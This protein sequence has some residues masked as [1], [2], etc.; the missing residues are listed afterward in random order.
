MGDFTFDLGWFGLAD[1]WQNRL[2]D[3]LPRQFRH[4]GPPA[5]GGLDQHPAQPGGPPLVPRACS[6]SL[7]LLTQHRR[8]PIFVAF[9]VPVA[10]GEDVR[11]LPLALRKAVL[12]RLAKGA[13]CWIAITD[14]VP[15][16]RAAGCSNSSPR[17]TSRDRGEAPLRSAERSGGRS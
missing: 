4:T 2:P 1:W 6:T 9:D 8:S 12:K 5:P 3:V 16:A 11:A 15:R 13:R 10:R 7:P 14:G 17:W